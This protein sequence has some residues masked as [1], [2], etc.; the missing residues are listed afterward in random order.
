[1]KLNYNAK[2]IEMTKKEAKEA[3]K[4]GSDACNKLMEIKRALPDFTI[5]VREVSHKSGNKGFSYNRMEMYVESYGSDDQKEQ[6]KKMRSVAKD[7]MGSTGN[8]YKEI[9]AWFNAT[10]PEASDFSAAMLRITDRAA[11]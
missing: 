1:M 8:A 3:S 10:F 4:Y 11:G 7:S 5:T 9:K 6:F 2:Q